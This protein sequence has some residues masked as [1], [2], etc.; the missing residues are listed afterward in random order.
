MPSFFLGK[1]PMPSNSRE[2]MAFPIPVPQILH[3]CVGGGSGDKLFPAQKR[4]FFKTAP[5]TKPPCVQN[6]SQPSQTEMTLQS[7]FGSSPCSAVR[8]MMG[9]QRALPTWFVCKKTTTL[10]L[11]VSL[12]LFYSHFVVLVDRPGSGQ[13]DSMFSEFLI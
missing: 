12:V 4:G 3:L 1:V 6:G 7:L 2:E 5:V 13:W 11:K 9:S 8:T 10:Q